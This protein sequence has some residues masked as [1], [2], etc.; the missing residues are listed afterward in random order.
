MKC[1]RESFDDVAR[2]LFPKNPSRGQDFL[3][4]IAFLD[5][6][7]GSDDSNLIA[8]LQARIATLESELSTPRW[9][10]LRA[11][12]PSF[13]LGGSSDP[14]FIKVLDD[15]SGSTGV[16]AYAF[17]ASTEEELFQV[18][19]MPH[20]WA[21]GDIRAH[22]HW[23]PVSTAGSAGLDVCWGLEYSW[24]AIGS[25]FGNTEFLYGDVQHLGSGETLTADTHY[26]TAIGD[27]SGLGKGISSMLICRIFRDATGVG[28]TD[29][30]TADAALLELDLHY[31]VDSFGSR[32]EYVK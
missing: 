26:L 29:D 15:G 24:A 12:A 2:V 27:I 19:Q 31:Q 21:G 17:D 20:S 11:P 30:Y 9:E 16:F 32:W 13:A 10:D 1:R 22:V 25:V 14:G 5:E 18:F 4:S 23:M 28:G 7:D 3:E 8:S 6:I